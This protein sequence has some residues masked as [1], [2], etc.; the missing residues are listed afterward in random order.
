MAEFV[1]AHILDDHRAGDRFTMWPLHVT[2]LPPFE[3]PGLESVSEFIEPIVRSE[4]PIQLQVGERA[5]FGP[6]LLVQKIVPSPELASLHTKL[7]QAGESAGWNIMGRYTGNHYTPHITQKAGRSFEA[8]AFLLDRLS[9]VENIGQG[10][11]VIHR[12]L[13]LGGQHEKAA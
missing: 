2:V 6:K 1:V 4:E 11:R 7:L 12:D 10:Y 3:A 8:A 9:I 13:K 5:K